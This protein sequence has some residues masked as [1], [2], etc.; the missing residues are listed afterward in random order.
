M[1]HRVGI[2]L[3]GFGMAVVAALACSSGS[4]GG[5]SGGGASCFAQGNSACASCVQSKCGSQ[6]SAVESGCSDFIGCVCP[7]GSFEANLAQGCYS[8]E[9]ESGCMSAVQPLTS[10]E[11]SNCASECNSTSGSGGSGG[12]SGSGS[13]SGSGGSPPGSVSCL[14]PPGQ[15]GTL[16]TPQVC[17][18]LEMDGTQSAAQLMTMCT[19]PGVGA[20]SGLGGMVVTSC[21]TSSLVG[22]CSSSSVVP[23]IEC[24]YSGT[25]QTNMG[26]CNGPWMAGP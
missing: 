22:C 3:F 21:P 20:T 13:G 19:S 12:G 23:S 5:G 26:S 25:Q 16:T 10:C 15:E 7:S 18:V 1:T 8:K 14:V 6:V 9:Q 24:F 2:S 4:S 11:M 17:Y